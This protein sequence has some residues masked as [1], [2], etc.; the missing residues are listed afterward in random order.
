MLTAFSQIH[1]V[2]RQWPLRRIA[3]AQTEKSGLK[4]RQVGQSLHSRFNTLTGTVRDGQHRC[5]H[6]AM[7]SAQ[8]R[9]R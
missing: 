5:S 3:F 4:S 8:L 7:S 1:N 9:M 2:A 6:H